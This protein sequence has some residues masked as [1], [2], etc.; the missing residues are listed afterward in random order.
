MSLLRAALGFSAVGAVLIVVYHVA[1]QWYL[2]QQQG[3]GGDSSDSGRRWAERDDHE[4]RSDSEQST[5]RNT[6]VVAGENME[7]RRRKKAEESDDETQEA[8]TVQTQKDEAELASRRAQLQKD[9]AELGWVEEQLS[10]I[11][12]ASS[13]AS[14]TPPPSHSIRIPTPPP[15]DT[16]LIIPSRSPSPSTHSALLMPTIDTAPINSTSHSTTDEILVPTPLIIPI[17]SSPTASSQ[18][19]STLLSPTHTHHSDLQSD[20]GLLSISDASLIHPSEH[21]DLHSSETAP[22]LP[23]IATTPIPV[24]VQH[25][26]N[27]AS[28][29][30]DTMQSVHTSDDTASLLS[31][32]WTDLEGVS[33]KDGSGSDSDEERSERPPSPGVGF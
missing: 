29:T 10:N 24:D 31:D 14:I 21:I 28:P 12:L 30:S 23:P 7:L 4:K 15:S 1:Q 17:T 3:Y 22:E 32:S 20:S 6:E 11:Q 2:N 9:L 25:A 16:H 18:T 13:S 27:L 19:H 5:S 8:A 26:S 33:E